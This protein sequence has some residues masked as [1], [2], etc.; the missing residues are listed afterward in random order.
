M[1]YFYAL[2]FIKKKHSKMKKIIFTISFFTI[3]S[4]NAQEF[5]VPVNTSFNYQSKT[6][7]SIS[8]T[9][10]LPFFVDFSA[11]YQMNNFEDRYVTISQSGANL[12]PSIGAAMFDAIDEKGNYYSTAYQEY[13]IA[14]YLTS[15]PIDLTLQPSQNVY[16]SFKYLP[17]G[18]LDA[19]EDQDSLVLQFY[20]PLS[21]TWQTVWKSTNFTATKFITVILKIDQSKFLQKGFKFRFFNYISTSPNTPNPSFVGNCDFWFVDYIYINKNRTTVDTTFA[22]IA[23]QMPL[24]FKFDDYQSVPYSHYK[25][26]AFK[27][28]HNAEIYFRNNDKKIRQIDSLNIMFQEKNN[29]DFSK[30]FFGSFALVS[31]NNS[32][33]KRQNVNFSL[34]TNIN[35]DSLEYSIRTILKTDSYDSVCNNIIIQSK[36]L[37]NFY[38][39]D[40]GTAENAY[41]LYGE[42]SLYA[43]VAQK[44]Y[45]FQKDELIG[46][47]VY[48][49]KPF[50]N[51]LPP[52]FQPVVWSNSTTS[53]PDTIL[54]IE[55]NPFELN[56]NKLN[57][58]QRFLFSESVSVSDSFYIGWKK[59]SEEL[60]NVG[61][62]INSSTNNYKYYLI[63]NGVWQKSSVSGVLMIRPLF[64]K[65]IV[66]YAKSEKIEFYPNPA[67]NFLNIKFKTENSVIEIF[68]LSGRKR[69][70]QIA[71]STDEKID[72]SDLDKGIYILKTI[73]GKEVKTAKFVV[74]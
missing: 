19:P 69:I 57:G 35:S 52:Y 12:P 55:E 41:G 33:I 32:S 45:T 72:I 71:Q 14:D 59:I 51:Q 64:G 17:K 38:S 73:E 18:N 68:D 54:Y 56:I 53:S 62:D 3:I 46:I 29:L 66:K 49:N 1:F 24:K 37:S 22:D 43:F 34:P 25:Q 23:F 39:Y 15:K 28:N 11:E 26:N 60:E 2:F 20:S 48:F 10:S 58:F 31:N 42:G 61:L 74:Q 16:F 63:S 9:L 6:K 50:N 36:S 44:F 21:N 5:V 47:D 40:D 8:D 67:K 7:I 27:I 70:S 4:L 13:R 65:K 30:L